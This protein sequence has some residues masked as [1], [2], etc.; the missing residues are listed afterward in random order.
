MRLAA[1]FFVYVQLIR[2]KFLFH[3]CA[4]H[5]FCAIIAYKRERNDYF[6][7]EF[8]DD[9]LKNQ[10]E[11]AETETE[12][13]ASSEPMADTEGSKAGTTTASTTNL[14][15]DVQGAKL[16]Y[17]PGERIDLSGVKFMLD[18]TDVTDKVSLSVKDGDAFPA[19]VVKLTVTASVDDATTSFELK[20]KR[21]I[22]PIILGLLAV[23]A[24][25]VGI[26]L[27][28]RP[29]EQEPFP[30]GDTGTYL[31]PKGDMSDEEAQKLV[32]EM[33]EKS[34]ITVSLAPEMRLESDGRLRVNLV[35]PE[36]NNGLSERLEIEQ[37]G[38]IVYRSGV[39]NPGNRL[40]WGND[41]N[42]AHEGPAT[43]TVYAIQDDA[44]FGNPVSVEVQIVAAS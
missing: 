10:P 38:K 15:A 16:A 19:D 18:G 20:R 23:A 4:E 3:Y 24:L 30:Q 32:D 13:N 41:A 8:M 25:I 39:V 9:Q 27:A 29:P 36:E 11:G 26:V 14:V 6:T 17:V 44:D 42:D 21:R 5:V 40:E 22:L 12:S 33:A 1:L 35:V 31:I 7:E 43:A 28:M 37:D 34:R 2:N